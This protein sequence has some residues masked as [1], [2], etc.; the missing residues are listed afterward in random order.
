MSKG[1]KIYYDGDCYFCQNYADFVRLRSVVGDA[2]LISLRSN[3]PDAQS[4][5]DR[6]Y[7]VNT[8]FVVEHDSHVFKGSAAFAHLNGLVSKGSLAGCLLASV[9]GRLGFA[10]LLYPLL[11][12]LRL[13]LLALQ[14]RALI[15]TSSGRALKEKLDEEGWGVRLLRISP[16][17]CCVS[18][19]L[20]LVLFGRYLSPGYYPVC[21]GL[22]VLFAGIFVALFVL[23]DWAIQLH[24]SLKSAG[25]LGLL[26]WFGAW[27]VIVNSGE[28][29]VQRR[30]MGFAASLPLLGIAV[31]FF[32]QHCARRSE[33]ERMPLVPAIFPAILVIFVL[34]PGF[35]I[36]PFYG[37]IAGWYFSID[38]SKPV[39]VSGIKFVNDDG[40][41]IWHN[42]ALL[43]PHTQIGRFRRAFT[44]RAG[45]REKFLRFVF[46]NY[47]RYHPLLKTGRLPHQWAL[48][49]WAYPPH[50]LTKNNALEYAAKFPPERVA[51]V[52]FET[53][54]YNWDGKFL[55]RNTGFTLHLR[56]E[57]KAK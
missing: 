41:T 3:D 30:F 10:R 24:R 43:Q 47:R 34:F 31:D 39:R 21:I 38:K 48:G 28:L 40:D 19:V 26:L 18:N 50:S 1:L 37:G 36:L 29:V 56:L 22:C 45:N 53:E 4:I 57:S 16:V 44:K 51:A 55:S 33:D 52:R 35:C 32:L 11:V 54:Y 2:R 9:G 12:V 27:L 17:V 7:N 25:W 42:S 13:A 49:T 5:I 23:Q 15:D 14:G 20:T 6:G 46:E 8:G